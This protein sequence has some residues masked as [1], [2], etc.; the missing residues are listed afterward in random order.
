MTAV[1]V[2]KMV[3]NDYVSTTEVFLF[4]DKLLGNKLYGNIV[5]VAIFGYI[6]FLWLYI[7]QKDKR[8]RVLSKTFSNL[9]VFD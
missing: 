7:S 3:Y 9:L 5:E 6:L 2:E 4:I 1:Q 8:T